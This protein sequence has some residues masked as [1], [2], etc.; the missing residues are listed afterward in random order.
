MSSSEKNEFLTTAIKAAR[1]AGQIILDNL[2]RISK[3]LEYNREIILGVIFDPLRNEL[4]TAEK[5]S[6]VFLT[7]RYASAT[8]WPS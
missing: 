5:G 4:F 7:Q 1:D 3:A 8:I 6:G 2:V